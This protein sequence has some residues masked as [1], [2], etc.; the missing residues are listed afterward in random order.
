M[1]VHPIEGLGFF[2]TC[3]I[4]GIIS[5]FQSYLTPIHPLTFAFCSCML[6]IVTMLTHCGYRLPVYDMI[7]A[8][9]PCHEAHHY[10]GPKNL[11][12]VFWICDWVF[13]TYLNPGTILKG[14]SPSP[15]P[16]IHFEARLKGKLTQ[17]SDKCE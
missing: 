8:N 9:N 11:S 4:Y 15:N 7:F 1:C 13:G 6:T 17:S 16:D 2:T 5:S 12:V 14:S 3:H 10:S